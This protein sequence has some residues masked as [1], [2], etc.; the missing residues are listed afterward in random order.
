MNDLERLLETTSLTAGAR[1]RLIRYA[2][3]VLEANARFNLTGA[4][5]PD[6]LA[7]HLLDSLTVL[8]Y[9][10]MP[11]VDVGSGAGLPAIPIAIETGDPV[12]MIES[13]RKK[14]GFLRSA[15]ATL[16][17]EGY[18]VAERA[19]TAGQDPELR[20]RFAS[21]TARA[22]AGPSAVA[23]LLLPFIA[24]GGAAILQRGTF[25]AAERRSLED[26]LL[27]LGGRLER[28]EPLEGNRRILLI[29]KIKPTPSRFPR[30]PGIP[31]KRPLC[32]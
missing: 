26:A 3:L 4:K 10:R 21:G 31:S 7:G 22:V 6:E 27:M 30:R 9:V 1:E 12:T 17:L 24:V 25:D 28:E 15:L 19:E 5:T 16:E 2:A 8:P 13:S 14:A 23:E 11:Y 29:Q 20:E 32:E 18:V